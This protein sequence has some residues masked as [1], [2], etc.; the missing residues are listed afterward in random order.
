MVSVD[1]IFQAAYSEEGPTIFAF[2][3]REIADTRRNK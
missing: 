3:M 2:G 1:Q